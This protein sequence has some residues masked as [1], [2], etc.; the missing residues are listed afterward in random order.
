MR[1]SSNFHANGS[2]LREDT[3]Y[4]LEEEE[5]LVS[6]T[7]SSLLERRYSTREDLRRK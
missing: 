5:E 1:T 2:F 7:Q 4:R 3:S 6:G